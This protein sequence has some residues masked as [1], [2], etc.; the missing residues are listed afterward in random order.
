MPTSEIPVPNSDG[1]YSVDTINFHLGPTDYGALPGDAAFPGIPGSIEGSS[2]TFSSE[3][4]A[5]LELSAGVHELGVSVS[6]ARTDVNDDDGYALYV[7]PDARNILSPVIATFNRGTVQPFANE[8]T[9]NQFRVVAPV[10]GIYPVRLVYFK[11]GLLRPT[12]MPALIVF[13]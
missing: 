4:L 12:T 6:T 3:V 2:D 10:A 5:Y 8:F 13:G 7:G 11:A 9:T 1:S